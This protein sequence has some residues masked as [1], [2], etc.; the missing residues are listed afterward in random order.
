MVRK[1]HL[2]AIRG[3]L[4]AQDDAYGQAILQGCRLGFANGRGR[5]EATSKGTGGRQAS[6]VSQTLREVQS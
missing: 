4:A 1:W 2:E 6:T 3:Q 5:R